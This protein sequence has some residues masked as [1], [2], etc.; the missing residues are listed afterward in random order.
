MKDLLT[1]MR[2]IRPLGQQDWETVARQYVTLS[3]SMRADHK[4][5]IAHAPFCRG[6]PRRFNAL[7]RWPTRTAISLRHK[8]N[9]LLAKRATTGSATR[10][11]LQDTA[12]EVRDLCERRAV[13]ETIDDEPIDG[14]A[15]A[16][17]AED[18]SA[19]G[20]DHDRSGGATDDDQDNDDDEPEERADAVDHSDSDSGGEATDGDGASASETE[21]AGT[22][23][24]VFAAVCTH[25]VIR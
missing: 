24:A 22:V 5:C 4:T 11:A 3:S 12:L 18:E 16:S 1:I 10:I 25:T 14:D 20:A 13:V 8:Y 2:Q 6:A 7:N 9:S 19:G 15:G 21:V 23:Q 17:E